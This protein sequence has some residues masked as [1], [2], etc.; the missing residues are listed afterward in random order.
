[1]KGNRRPVDQHRAG[2]SASAC[3]PAKPCAS[4]EGLGWEQLPP[5][6]TAG[7]EAP[8]TSAHGERE[9][10][11]SSRRLP[12]CIY[13]QAH[14]RTSTLSRG[15]VPHSLISMSQ[16]HRSSHPGATAG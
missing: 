9:M 3:V 12:L 2:L 7:G 10:K 4:A 16:R 1:M 6:G 5:H 8:W 15:C 13:M 11:G 14:L